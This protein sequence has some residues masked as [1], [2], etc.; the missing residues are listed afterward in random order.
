[1]TSINSRVTQTMSNQANYYKIGLFVV[2]G[3]A[4][5]IVSVVILGAGS[6]FEKSIVME[7]YIDGSVQGLDVGSAVKFRGVQIGPRQ[8]DRRG[9]LDL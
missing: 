2:L 5:A 8:Q 9:L 4:I 3:V 1:M 7:T 6:I